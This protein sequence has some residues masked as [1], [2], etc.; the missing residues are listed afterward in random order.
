[1]EYMTAEQ[2]AKAARG[3]T[4]EKVWA[5]L[6]EH[7]AEQEE[8][9]KRLNQMFEESNIRIE[10]LSKWA[11]EEREEILPLF[12]PCRRVLRHRCGSVSFCPIS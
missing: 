7:R 12:P 2:A 6:M 1:M 8:A 9:H 10:K 11:K 3:L 4:F 5:A